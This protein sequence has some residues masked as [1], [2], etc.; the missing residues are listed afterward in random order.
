MLSTSTTMATNFKPGILG[1][2]R[3]WSDS[4]SVQRY[5]YSYSKRPLKPQPT[6]THEPLDVYP[7]SIDYMAFSYQIVK[8]P[9]RNKTAAAF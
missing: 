2:A 9:R 4:Y 8:S 3:P 7:L 6:F 1:N 5:S